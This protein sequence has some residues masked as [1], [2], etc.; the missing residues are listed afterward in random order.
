MWR[1]PE[2]HRRAQDRR[3]VLE[4]PDHECGQRTEQE[5]EAEGAADREADHAGPQEQRQEGEGPG[6]RPDERLDGLDRDAQR[7]GPVGPLGGGT[8][9]D[10][11]VG[12]AQQCT[13]TEQH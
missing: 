12:V 11:E 1:I 10:A 6:D 2:R 8:D 3:Q 5:P 7:A 9:G 4:P 13:D